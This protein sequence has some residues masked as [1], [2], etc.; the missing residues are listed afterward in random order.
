[1]V[2]YSTPYGIGILIREFFHFEGESLYIKSLRRLRERRLPKEI[3]VFYST[4][5]GIGILIREN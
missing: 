2:F 4:P 1:M 3:M 5:Y